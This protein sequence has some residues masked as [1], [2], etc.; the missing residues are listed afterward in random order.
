MS[1]SALV[2]STPC[3]L[4]LAELPPFFEEFAILIENL[5]AVVTAVGDKKPALTIEGEHVRALQFAVA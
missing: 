3:E 1:Y 5:D 2:S 4:G